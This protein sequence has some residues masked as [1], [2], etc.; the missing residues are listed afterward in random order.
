MDNENLKK[1]LELHKKTVER[2]MENNNCNEKLANKAIDIACDFNL[3]NESDL[4]KMAT[5]IIHTIK[6]LI[7]EG[8]MDDLGF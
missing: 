7:S 5:V 3:E 1:S 4:D 6:H 8:E 2:I